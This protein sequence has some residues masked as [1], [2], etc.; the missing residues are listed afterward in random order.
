MRQR[1]DACPDSELI[2]AYMEGGLSDEE[3]TTVTDHLASCEDCYLLFAESLR[4]EVEAQPAVT[5]VVPMWRR[6]AISAAGLAAAAMLTLTVQP[7]AL[8]SAMAW[9]RPSNQAS[10][11]EL[12]AAVGAQ[13]TVEPRLTGGFACGPLRSA[14]RSCASRLDTSSPDVRIAVAKIEKRA[15]QSRTPKTLSALGEAFVAIGDGEQA[16]AALE[17]ATSTVAP[18]PKAWSDLAAAYLVR[19]AQKNQREDL[20]AALA[21][22]DTAIKADPSLAEAWFNRALALE[23]GPTSAEAQHAWDDYLRV[24]SRSG[25]ADEARRHLQ[26]LKRLPAKP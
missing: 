17:E 1:F 18:E 26:A 6:F 5:P 24:D 25:W 15:I 21:A 22:A 7:A 19:S 20:G 16:V 10:V 3:R 8:S 4:T 9:L 12:V 11:A 2:A 13:R 23:R 14:V